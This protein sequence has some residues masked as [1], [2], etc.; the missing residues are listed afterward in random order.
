MSKIQRTKEVLA[1]LCML[2]GALIM[3]LFPEDSYILIAF[4][5]SV[6]LILS[7]IRALVYYFSMAR[8]MVGGQ[9]MLYK[10]LIILD[11][12]LFTWTLTDIPQLYVIL[13]LLICHAFAGAVDIMR[14]ME[15]RRFDSPT[16]KGNMISGLV[17]ISVATVS[18]IFGFFVHSPDSIIYIYSACL[19]YSAF[20]RIVSAFRKTAIIY[21]Q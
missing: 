20:V 10:G 19:V 2:L 12:G 1:G 17:N 9:T 4:F 21:I 14:A 15:S 7:G 6:S 16:W 8:H 3:F 18:V 5:L 11:L 13:Y